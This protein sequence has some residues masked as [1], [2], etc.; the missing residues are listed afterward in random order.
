MAKSLLL[1]GVVI[2]VLISAGCRSKTSGNAQADATAVPGE[3][4]TMR[5]VDSIDEAGLRKLI[6]E[7]NG[8]ILFLN[9]WATW[10][11]PCVE[12]FP[13]LVKLSRSY[14]GTN[15]EVV[16]ISADDPD[17]VDAKI[18]PFLS[19]L[20]VP[21]RVSVAMFDHQEDFINAVNPSWDGSLPASMI[22]DTQGKRK[23]YIVGKGTFEQFKKEIDKIRGIS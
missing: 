12:E 2:A 22:F 9:I 5:T 19:K 16:G 23:F 3:R 18:I 11:T 4:K 6:S 1:T 17:E 21:Y 8:K 20:E 14:E 10:C 7:R 15:V 13:D